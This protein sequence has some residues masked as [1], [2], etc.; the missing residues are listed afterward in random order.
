MLDL[1]D[2][3][4]DFDRKYYTFR[5]SEKDMAPYSI[6]KQKEKSISMKWHFL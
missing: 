4:F 2:S 3:L 6:I 5:R 1:F